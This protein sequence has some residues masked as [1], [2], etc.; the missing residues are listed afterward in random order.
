MIKKYNLRIAALLSYLS[1]AVSLLSGVIITPWIITRIGQAEYGIYAL[2][3]SLI[4]LFTFDFGLS[5]TITR[6]VS[7]FLAEGNKIRE[8]IF[9]KYIL[10]FFTLMSMIIALIF[11]FVFVNAESIY[12]ELN[13]EELVIFK[14]VFVIAATY[15][16]FSFPFKPLD[17]LLMS[18]EKLIFFKLLDF[19]N[20]LIVLVS[21]IVVLFFG[22]G[23]VGLI[24]VNTT[25]GLTIVFV[26]I[27]YVYKFKL[28]DL[29]VKGKDRL[30]LKEIYGF[31][32]WTTLIALSSRLIYNLSPSIIAA[33][34]GSI[35]VSI[36]SIA[37]AIESYVW[38]IAA[39]LNGLFLPKITKMLTKNSN[40]SIIQELS[41]KVGRIQLILMS[42]ILIGFILLGR[43]FLLLWVG[44]DFIN[45]YYITLLII[46][47]MIITMPTQIAN[48][49]LIAKG[50][51]KH[52][53]IGIM[54]QGVVSIVLTSI[55]SAKYG[56]LGAGIGIF[57]GILIGNI[58]YINIVYK[59][60][61][62]IDLKDFYVKTYSKMFMPVVFTLSL[63]II[64]NNLLH[65][66]TWLIFLFKIIFISIMFICLV[67]FIYINKSEKY[68]IKHIISM[69]LH[70]IFG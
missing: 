59:R 36:F 22:V 1:V 55:F 12:K 9:L 35:E 66:N 40:I 21:T 30:L 41:I 16:V 28:L 52:R 45:A 58:V 53:A 32:I 37:S 33:L 54:L 65:D 14:S 4:A 5:D 62:L 23:I 11:A 10:A 6:F 61:L 57:F 51:I 31:T 44:S 63:G 13:P 20:R 69:I 42:I 8:K 7:K 27:I 49:A 39:A 3:L 67:W 46:I 64:L 60:I 19:I 50:E 70:K 18:Y 2:T 29:R 15:A 26:K 38:T 48:T 68:E 47:P 34:N 25:S 43:D 56:A 17:G 24:L